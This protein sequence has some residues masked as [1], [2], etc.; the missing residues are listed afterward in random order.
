MNERRVVI[1]GMGVVSPVGNNLQT[2]WESLKAGRSGISRI[3]AFDTSAYHCHIAG[4]VRNFDYVPFFNVPKDGK[5]CDRYAGFAVA[6]AKMALQDSGMDLNAIDPARVGVM[7]GSG[8][9]GLATLE[10]EHGVLLQRAPNRVSPF[11]IPMMISNIGSGIISM[12]FGL[13]GPNMVVVTACATSNNNIGEAWRIIKFGDA[14]AMLC[15]GA[16]ASILPMG[17][18]GFGNM[19]A[20]SLRND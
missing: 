14:D 4:E 18:S 6:A 15:G 8:I 16:E 19:K 2:F 12:E 5:R 1:T 20:L 13:T 11:V 9:G 10:R 17:L 7:V 3:A